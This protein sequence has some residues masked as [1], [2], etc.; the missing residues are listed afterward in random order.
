M[1][2]VQ[3][4]TYPLPES[5]RVNLENELDEKELLLNQQKKDKHKTT[6]KYRQHLAQ[7]EQV[8]TELAIR[9]RE[10]QAKA[11]ADQARLLT[12][13]FGGPL[14]FYARWSMT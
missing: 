5:C 11:Q 9:L 12:F 1:I 8:N 10:Q 2:Q 13:E 6:K 14:H 7:Q 4:S 3:V